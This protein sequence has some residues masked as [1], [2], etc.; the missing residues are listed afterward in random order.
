MRHGNCSAAS[1]PASTYGR[2]LGEQHGIGLHDVVV[3]LSEQLTA[4]MRNS[5]SIFPWIWL[6][7]SLC[8][9]NLL[10]E[11]AIVG[12]DAITSMCKPTDILQPVSHTRVFVLDGPS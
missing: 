7:V 5:A 4:G 8:Y 12:I 2:R 9:G 10:D 3:L 6:C 1:V 11:Q